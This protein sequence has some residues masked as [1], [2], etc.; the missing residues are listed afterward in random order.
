MPG[1]SKF[2]GSAHGL[3]SS[4]AN[5]TTCNILHVDIC[6]DFGLGL[7]HQSSKIFSTG[8]AFKLFLPVI[9][10][11]EGLL[12]HKR[13]RHPSTK[14]QN[15]N[16][17]AYTCQDTHRTVLAKNRRQPDAA[18]K[19]SKRSGVRYTY[20]HTRTKRTDVYLG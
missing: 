6:K 11:C 1:N 8:K 20:V 18:G 13:S 16:P 14:T 3:V 17:K 4:S 10:P 2:K 19:N 9:L 5:L 12:F 7:L 15:P